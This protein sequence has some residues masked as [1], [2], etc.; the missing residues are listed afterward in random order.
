MAV[1]LG[2]LAAEHG[3]C[4]TVDVADRGFDHHRLAF[5]ERRL[6]LFDQFVIK[7]PV[8]LVVLL[9]AMEAGDLG[10]GL[11]IV[12]DA[13]KIEAM[14]LP[15]LGRLA[16][17]QAIDPSDHLL[18]GT[19]AHR[20]HDLAQFLGDEQEVV[21]HVLGL[22]D[23]TLAQHRVLG[24]DAGRAG[25][26]M[27]LAHHQAPFRDQRRGG[28]AEL[29]GTEQGTDGD[30]APGP[31]AAVDLDANTPAQIVHHQRLVGFG[32]ADFPG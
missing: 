26:E 7:G 9:L 21:D 23:E 22:A 5:L 12:D 31:Q 10:S 24:G 6:G 18:D 3:A 15:V 17:V 20:R 11:R 2:D 19:E 16:D 8:Q 29:V 14:G 4:G 32:E 28:E 27:A 30:V 25:V 1:T 13:R